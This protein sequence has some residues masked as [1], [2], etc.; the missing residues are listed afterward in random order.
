MRKIIVSVVLAAGLVA[1]AWAQDAP[2]PLTPEQE[3]SNALKDASTTQLG[4]VTG[5]DLQQLL[6]RVAVAEQKVRYVQRVR[7]AS[8]LYPGVG[9]FMTGNPGAGTLFAVG[10]LAIVAGTLVGAYYLLP[11]NVQ[12]NSLDYLNAPLQTIHDRWTGNSLLSYLPSWGVMAGGMIVKHLLGVFAARDA[13]QD[14]RRNI[15]AGKVTFQPSFGFWGDG[16]HMGM[17]MGMR[18][19]Y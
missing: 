7:T 12:F 3:L 2:A 16:L 5:A 18:F 8:L 11:A 17:G 1:A 14:A 10:D 19:S 6:M 9:Q 15:A 4:S 13:A